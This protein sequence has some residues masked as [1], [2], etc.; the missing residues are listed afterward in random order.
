MMDR[1]CS[2]ASRRTSTRSPALSSTTRSAPASAPSTAPPTGAAVSAP[3]R[4]HPPR[5]V[6]FVVLHQPRPALAAATVNWRCSAEH[7]AAAAQHFTM[8]PASR[9]VPAAAQHFTMLPAVSALFSP[10]LTTC[11]GSSCW[12]QCIFRREDAGE[13]LSLPV[14]C[15]PRGFARHRGVM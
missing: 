5:F 3:A 9:A 12:A 13:W 14:Y 4:F 11:V 7:T 15:T 8:L 6:M 1:R 2:G 10:A